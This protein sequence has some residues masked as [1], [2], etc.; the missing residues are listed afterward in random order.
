MK[1]VL[2]TVEVSQE[3]LVRIADVLDGKQSKRAA[4][5]KEARAF[6]WE[7]GEDWPVLLTDRWNE[8]FDPDSA[9]DTEDEDLIGPDGRLLPPHRIRRGSLGE[10][11]F[12][13]EPARGAGGAPMI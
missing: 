5:R 9:P 2:E 12:I 4:T 1:I 13:D 8:L 10:R 7:C 3:Q 11:S 6:V